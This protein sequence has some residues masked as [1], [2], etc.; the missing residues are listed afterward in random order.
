[1][2]IT[3]TKVGEVQ[4]VA[5]T[6]RFDAQTAL[7]VETKLKQLVAAGNVKMIIDLRGVEYISSSGLRVL[8]GTLKECRKTENGDCRLAAIQPQVKQVFEMAGFTQIFNI[9]NSVEEA[10]QCYQ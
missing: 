8:L 3:E 9:H 10:I 1:M 5:L 2:I 4:Q 6:G 7:D